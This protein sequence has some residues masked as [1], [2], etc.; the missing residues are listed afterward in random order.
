LSSRS[1]RGKAHALYCL[2]VLLLAGS[3]GCWE[4]WSNAWWPQMKWQPAVQ[5]FE[6]TMFEGRVDPFLP[7]EGAVPIDGG[8]AP[9]DNVV[10]AASDG[11][12]NPRP[13]RLESLERGRARF[14]SFCSP[15]HGAGGQGD[16]PVS[17][18]G[19]LKGPFVGVL[20]VAGPTSIARVRSDGHLYTSIRYGRRRMPG[21]ARIPSAE[22]WDIVNYL[23]YLNGQKGVQP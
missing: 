6:R 8:E 18:T 9:V 20:A 16:G 11:L 2:V 3:V 17:M 5:A 1:G 12:V 14:E 23:R 15:C 10:D 13:M 4:Q 21:Y 7:P 22:R 19:P